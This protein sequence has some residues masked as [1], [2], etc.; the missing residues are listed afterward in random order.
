MLAGLA[1]AQED[2]SPRAMTPVER[3]DRGM[4]LLEN[5]I[6]DE[7]GDW[8]KH[9]KLLTRYGW[10]RERLTENMVG[11]CVKKP[12]QGGSVRHAE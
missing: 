2:A 10:M 11:D 1:F 7:L 5:W 6:N 3:F 12:T 4:D 8:K 9:T